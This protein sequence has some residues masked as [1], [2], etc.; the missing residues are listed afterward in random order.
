MLQV[1]LLQEINQAH[2]E[3]ESKHRIAKKC[4][5]HVQWQPKRLKSRRHFGGAAVHG[6]G[7]KGHEKRQRSDNAAQHSETV[8][9]VNQQIYADHEPTIEKQRVTHQRDGSKAL[10][11][12]KSAQRYG[13]HCKSGEQKRRRQTRR[14]VAAKEVKKQAAR[15]DQIHCSG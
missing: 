4:E 14:H 15:R 2:T 6:K 3:S 7:G 5:G 1:A 10:T 12:E 11:D 13:M 8:F 9:Q